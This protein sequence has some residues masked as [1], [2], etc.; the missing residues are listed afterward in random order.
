MARKAPRPPQT[1][2]AKP[3]G[4]VETRTRLLNVAAQLFAERGFARVTV[5]DICKQARANVAAVNYHF[6]GKEGLYTAVMRRAIE[7]MQATTA[8]AETAGR[9]QPAPERL[10]AYVSVFLMRM[11]G[12]DHASWIHQLMLRELSDPTPALDMVATDVLKPRTAY[13]CGII[14]ELIGCPATSPLVMR[15]AMSVQGQFNS[16]LWSQAV[17]RMIHIAEMPVPTLDEITEHV[18]QFSLGGVEEIRRRK[19]A[20]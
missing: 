15:C 5:R 17:T 9:G 12:K 19:R 1:R 16:L 2:R 3:A 11:L 7:V 10:R 20:G 14:G 6:G 4:D 18:T 13:L 8:E